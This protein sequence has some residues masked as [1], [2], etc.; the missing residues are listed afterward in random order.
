MKPQSILI[1]FTVT[2]PNI[3]NDKSPRFIEFVTEI[4]GTEEAEVVGEI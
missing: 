3:L 2:L 4:Q 1:T